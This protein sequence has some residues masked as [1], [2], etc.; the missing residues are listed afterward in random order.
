MTLLVSFIG[1]LLRVVV[2]TYGFLLLDWIVAAAVVHA[3]PDVDINRTI[4]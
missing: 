2:V 3:F 1:S 4:L